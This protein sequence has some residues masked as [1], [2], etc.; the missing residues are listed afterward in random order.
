[1]ETLQSE[2]LPE[3]AAVTG[4]QF[5][6]GLLNLAKRHRI[7]SEIR[8]MGL[9][10]GMELTVPAAPIVGSLMTKGYLVT[11]VGE[12]TV[13]FTPPLNIASEDIQGILEALDQVL[14]E[15]GG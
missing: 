9:L 3:R 14:E 15:N 4:E 13:R 10:L 12:Q 2:G 11:T 8:G 1:L 6:T 7:V 5:R